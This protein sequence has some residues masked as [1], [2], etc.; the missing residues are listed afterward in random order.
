MSDEAKNVPAPVPAAE[1]G[2]VRA[3]PPW[4]EELKVWG[5]RTGLAVAFYLLVALLNKA[6][7]KVE[8]TPPPAPTIVVAPTEAAVKDAVKDAVKQ[9]FR[10]LVR[11]GK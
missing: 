2:T 7:I 4:L 5:I 3:R 1:V 9:E 10:Q 11:E 6:G 8:L